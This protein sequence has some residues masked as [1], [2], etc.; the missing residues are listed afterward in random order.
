GRLGDDALGGLGGR[1]LGL[2][3]YKRF[4]RGR[5]HPRRIGIA[6]EGLGWRPI[7]GKSGIRGDAWLHQPIE[8]EEKA[9]IGCKH[10]AGG[11]AYPVILKS[12]GARSKRIH[13]LP[14]VESFI[15][16]APWP[17][18]QLPS[19]FTASAGGGSG[20]SAAAAG[21]GKKARGTWGLPPAPLPMPA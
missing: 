3:R 16:R 14:P 11:R 1:R 18:V 8:N 15:S 9:H 19:Q 7:R 20:I 13:V 21:R 10:H 6:Q 12:R 17:M 5:W 4:R 2:G